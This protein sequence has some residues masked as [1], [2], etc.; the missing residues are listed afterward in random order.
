MTED[1]T[2]EEIEDPIVDILK[3]T[4][5]QSEAAEIAAQ[6]VFQLVNTMEKGISQKLEQI[7]K[8]NVSGQIRI[9]KS[10]LKSDLNYQNGLLER[11]ATPQQQPKKTNSKVILLVFFVIGFLLS[12]VSFPLALS[13]NIICRGI[14]GAVAQSADGQEGC[15]FWR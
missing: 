5:N 6:K 3:K 15:V 4:C 12:A 8:Q 14:G 10:D 2:N 1:P 7:E 11:M 9:L 13:T